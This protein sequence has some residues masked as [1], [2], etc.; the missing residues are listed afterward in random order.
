MLTATVASASGTPSAGTVTFFDTSAT[1]GQV[2]LTAGRAV[3]STATLARGVHAIVASYS[4][5]GSF[6]ASKSPTLMQTVNAAVASVTL[7]SDPN[8]STRGQ[9]VTFTATVTGPPG[10]SPTGTVAFLDGGSRRLGSAPL[11]NMT[12]AYSTSALSAG[13]HSVTAAYQGDRNFGPVISAPVQQQVSPGQCLA[14]SISLSASPSPSTVGQTVIFAAPV[15]WIGGGT[16]I[17]NVT[18]SESL[19]NNQVKYWGTANLVSGTAAFQ[20]NGLPAGTHRMYATYGGD[21]PSNHC[22]ATSAS[23][24]QMVNA[25]IAQ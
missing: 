3:F 11:S 16:P 10:T 25:S 23:F 5:D 9:L 6:A 1:L 17:G 22:G 21:R 2:P 14:S 19:E 24:D 7:K 18:L 13:T 8:P 12:A 20:V 4:G 15:T